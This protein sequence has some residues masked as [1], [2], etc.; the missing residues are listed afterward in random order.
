MPTLDLAVALRVVGRGP[1]VRHATQ[2]DVLLEVLGDELRAIIR[3]DSRRHAWILLPASLQ[4]GLDIRLIGHG[5]PDFPVDDRA[6]TTVEDATQV[7]KRPGE[8]EVRH[9]HMPVF[10]R[11]QRVG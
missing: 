6:A 10:V 1:H 7:V 9:V 2:P 4:D 5:F 3:D 11:S 8:V